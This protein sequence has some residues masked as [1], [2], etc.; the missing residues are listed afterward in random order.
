MLSPCCLF[1][2]VTPGWSQGACKA[3]AKEAW[4]LAI[5]FS[6][7]I[8][9]RVGEVRNRAIYKDQV[10]LLKFGR[11]EHRSFLMIAPFPLC[12]K[13]SS[14]Q[15]SQWS[16]FTKLNFH[17][18]FGHYFFALRVESINKQL[19]VL[20]IAVF[21]TSDTWCEVSNMKHVPNP[22]CFLSRASQ[23]THRRGRDFHQ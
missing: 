19:E 7:Q 4:H 18:N 10:L 9:S 12:K 1:F 17:S 22:L 20:Q 14:I 8:R 16:L 3:A 5:V 23:D 15:Y 2:R 6:H 11:W 21:V 13:H